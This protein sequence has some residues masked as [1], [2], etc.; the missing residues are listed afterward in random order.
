MT[1]VS[2]LTSMQAS[3]NLHSSSVLVLLNKNPLD[4]KV[5]LH[6]LRAGCFLHQAEG[7]NSGGKAADGGKAFPIRTIYF[8]SQ[9]AFPEI[10]SFTYEAASM[11]ARNASL[12]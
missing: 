10:N 12:P 2:R 6:L 9:S 1:C 8:E 11:Y 3:E 7:N 4:S 5:L